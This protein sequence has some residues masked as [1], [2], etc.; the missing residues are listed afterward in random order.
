MALPSLGATARR[1]APACQALVRLIPPWKAASVLFLSRDP[2]VEREGFVAFACWVRPLIGRVCIVCAVIRF[3][4]PAGPAAAE[5]QRDL[6]AL[7][8]VAFGIAGIAV[9]G[10]VLILTTRPEVRRPTALRMLI[11]LRAVAVFIP[12]VVLLA[13]WMPV[14]SDLN[15]VQA[16]GLRQMLSQHTLAGLALPG[17]VSLL[18]LWALIFCGVMLYAAPRHLFRAADAHPL[19]PPLLAAWIAWTVTVPELGTLR[20][21]NAAAQA[22]SAVTLGAPISLTLLGLIEIAR[23]S[24]HDGVTFRSGPWPNS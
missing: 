10:T 8:R 7:E 12:T 13:H 5:R 6:A 23:L 18:R 11:P 17:A 3:H 15:V 21:G 1:M 20:F 4:L 2:L 19:L 16:L 9:L 22:V 24:L 14:G